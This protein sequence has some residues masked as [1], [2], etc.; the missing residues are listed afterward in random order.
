VHS[1][2]ASILALYE[3]GNIQCK[4]KSPR[5]K[6]CFLLGGDL[7]LLCAEQCQAYQECKI[8]FGEYIK[9]QMDSESSIEEFYQNH[10][11]QIGCLIQQAA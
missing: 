5:R 4:N 9:F 11:K 2:R 10:V 1:V 3:M 8:L 7:T 6:L